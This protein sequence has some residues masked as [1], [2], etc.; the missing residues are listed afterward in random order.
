M[1][2]IFKNSDEAFKDPVS[3]S[4]D[5]PDYAEA[6]FN[7]GV[8]C[9]NKGDFTQAITFYKEGI[10]H[11]LCSPAVFYNL[12]LCY[13]EM[14]DIKH[15]IDFFFKAIEK[16]ND[17]KEAILNCC[18]L[19]LKYGQEL[20]DNQRIDEAIHLYL[21]CLCISFGPQHIALLQNL[22]V[23][24]AIKGDITSAIK[25]VVRSLELD[26]MNAF[27]YGQLVKLRRF[28][29]EDIEFIQQMELLLNRYTHKQEDQMRLCWA[30]GKAYDDI[31]SYHKAFSYYKKANKIFAKKITFNIED[32]IRFRDKM[33]SVF[34]H[35][36]IRQLNRFGNT[37]RLPVLIVGHNR[38]GTTLLASKLSMLDK[39]YSAGELTFFPHS[40]EGLPD[41][42][43]E[44][45]QESIQQLAK[46]YLTILNNVADDAICVIDK[47]PV[48]F[49]N[50]GWILTLFPDAKIIHCKRHPL[51]ICLSNFFTSYAS[52]N[53]FS[54]DLHNIAMYFKTYELLMQYW[55]KLF[56]D[57]IYTVYYENFISNTEQIGKKLVDWLALRWNNCF[58]YHQQN[59]NMVYTSSLCQVR[60]Q[61]YHSSINRWKNYEHLI[62]DIKDILLNDIKEYEKDLLADV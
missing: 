56:K 32:H 10:K 49:V 11:H 8:L 44:A 59:K 50:I 48:N 23:M 52:G 16:K 42:I 6:Q 4:I 20:H 7:M 54:Y 55:Y 15:A 45:T 28:T 22:A 46:T 51:D 31:N 36:H 19:S 3:I 30:L 35:P 33:I 62:G 21:K 12:A 9:Q 27:S 57:K 53:R 58:L 14:N 18:D 1:N 26:P 61:I 2:K 60:Q 29:N 47:M 24:Y 38:T 34:Q 43:P 25:C 40:V 37:S 13:Y 41:N 17:F 5:D 39:V